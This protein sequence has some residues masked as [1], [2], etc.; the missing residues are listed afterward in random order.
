MTTDSGKKIVLA[1]V[2]DL[3]RELGSLTG[4]SWHP[5]DDEGEVILLVLCGK[6]D[7]D[8]ATRTIK[9][10]R[11]WRRHGHRAVRLIVREVDGE[12]C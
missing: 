11:A 5:A 2:A 10:T 9:R 6:G 4:I 3:T 12:F 7:L 8:A 1:L